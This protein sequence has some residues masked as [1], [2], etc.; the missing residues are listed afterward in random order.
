MSKFFIRDEE[1]ARAII[2]AYENCSVCSSCPLNTPEGWRCSYLCQQAE[3]YIR[4][5][6]AENDLRLD[7]VDQE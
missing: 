2:R 3:N 1:Q 4:Q 5:H 7:N 6:T